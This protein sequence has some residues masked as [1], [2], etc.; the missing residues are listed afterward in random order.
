MKDG[1]RSVLEL[2]GVVCLRF[3]PV[4][5][6]WAIWLLAVNGGC[7]LFITHVEAQVLLAVTGLAVIV[8]AAIY[9]RIG[10]TR[11]LG[12]VHLMWVPM[13]IWM[14]TRAEAIQADPALAT[15]IAVLFATNLVSLV[16]DIAEVIRFAR[17]DRAPHYHWA[18]ASAARGL[19]A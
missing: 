14:A 3:R 2:F 16:I 1:I 8:Q 18:K 17:G 12:I 19:A 11:V 10:F 5:R 15:W 9:Q 13:F 4:P 6:I 7:L